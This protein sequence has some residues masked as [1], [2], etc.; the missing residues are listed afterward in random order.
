MKVL[1]LTGGSG[2]GKS[3]AASFLASRG[4]NVIDADAVYH[5]L[6]AEKGR[7][8]WAVSRAF[9]PDILLPDGTLDRRKLASLVF[10]P[11]GRE[12]LCRLNEAVHPIVM[13]EIGKLLS[14]AER[15]GVPYVVLDAPQLFEAG[16][17][18]L[19]DATAAVL[20][21]RDL[22]IRRLSERDALP[23]GEAARRIDAQLPDD[24]F[25][26]HCDFILENNGTADQ[27]R[28]ACETL[29]SRLGVPAPAGRRER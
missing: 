11:D 14:K 24:Y 17:D 2:S 6:I 3:V 23:A 8:T 13:R 5:R 26:E 10:A 19:C 20:A 4:G 7:C 28:E 9:G 25:R 16:A 1:G 12:A 22:R 15:S 18:R 21:D 29:L 27:L